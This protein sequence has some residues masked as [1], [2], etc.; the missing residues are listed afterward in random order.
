MFGGWRS[1]NDNGRRF[2]G[3]ERLG[4]LVRPFALFHRSCVD[5]QGASVGEYA[6]MVKGSMKQRNEVEVCVKV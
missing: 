1:G 3:V 4:I 6:C 2:T 5:G